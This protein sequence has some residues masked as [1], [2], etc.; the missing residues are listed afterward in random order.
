MK[1]IRVFP[2][3]TSMTPID[4]YAFVGYPPLI[5]SP[6]DEVHIS[7]TFTWDMQKATKLL[8]AWEQYYPVVKIGGPAFASPSKDFQPG[9]YVR[10]DVTFT[11]RGCNKRCPGCLVPEREGKLRLIDVKP[12]YIV[13]DNNF[14]QAPRSH[15]SK[16]FDMLK[17]QR[18]AAVFSGGLDTDYIDQWVAD[19]LRS[20]RINQVF[21]SCD[22]GGRLFPLERAVQ[23]LNY[24]PREKLRCYVMTGHAGESLA[25][26]ERRLRQIYE[27][28]CLPFAQLY[29][30]AD[31]FIKYPPEW[32]ALARTWSRPAAM[33][34]EMKKN[35]RVVEKMLI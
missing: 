29:Q 22:T 30:P 28:G 21:L 6:A 26:A 16:V 20:L 5:R 14:L 13:Q 15:I 2:R 10:E 9:L 19:E 4:D 1:T 24:L 34:A 8:M 11:T 32:K 35:H 31:R 12:G 25:V 3:R 7:V 18:R 33:K 17:K 23:R 27:I